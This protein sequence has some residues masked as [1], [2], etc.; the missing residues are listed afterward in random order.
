MQAR[1]L[2]TAGSHILA[3]GDRLDQVD[4]ALFDIDAWRAR[5]ALE[6]L[7]SEGR[8]AAAFVSHQGAAYVLR[9]YRRGGLPG[10]LFDDGYLWLGLERSRPWREWQLL[11]E[12]YRM[13]LPAPRPVAV[14]VAHSG[15]SY[16]GDILMTRVPGRPLSALLAEGELTEGQW[17]AVGR[18][19]ARFHA[20]GIFHADLNAHNILLDGEQVSLIDFDRGELRDP[21]RWAEVNLRRLQ[22]SLNK[23]AAQYPAFH[24]APDAWQQLRSAWAEAQGG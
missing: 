4:E 7:S 12:L 8:G 13:E 21:G 10:K 2:N 9:H 24:Y 11:T 17:R 14:R 22:R 18:T 16:R 19:L 20:Q 5:G 1:Y 23:L 6:G 15:L 3:D